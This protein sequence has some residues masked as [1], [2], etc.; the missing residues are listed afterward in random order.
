MYPPLF[1]GCSARFRLSERNIKGMRCATIKQKRAE[2]KKREKKK[3]K[4][5][6]KEKGR[7]KRE[8]NCRDP[9]GE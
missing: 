1:V 6:R 9:L 3:K 5:K 7:G 2:K 4:K 8:E